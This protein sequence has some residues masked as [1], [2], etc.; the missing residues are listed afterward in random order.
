MIFKKLFKQLLNSFMKR[1]LGTSDKL[2][3]IS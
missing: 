2:L 1:E 3:G